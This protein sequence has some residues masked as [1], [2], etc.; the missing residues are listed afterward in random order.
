MHGSTNHERHEPF[1][2]P[3]QIA[4]RLCDHVFLS[5]HALISH[6]ES[7]MA[8]EET[9]TAPRR[10]HRTNR[11][12]PQRDLFANSL[13]PSFAT[14]PENRL[15]RPERHPFLGVNP[16]TFA[17]P[18]PTLLSPQVSLMARNCFS[19]A[20]QFML[21]APQGQ[22]RVA[23]EPPSD[24][25]KPYLDQLEQPIMAI[26]QASDRN[27]ENNGFSGLNKLDLALKL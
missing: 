10:Q 27:D 26:V 20:P 25:T 23:D 17:L 21:S 15:P 6:I 14:L 7:H 13:Q 5:T 19:H 9:T 24:C 18:P 2:N 12:P 1:Y 4:C 11:M 3:T 22:R 8:E 16:S